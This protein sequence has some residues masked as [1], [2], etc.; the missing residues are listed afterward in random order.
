MYTNVTRVTKKTGVDFGLKIQ[1]NAA[2]MCFYINVKHSFV[3][4][5]V[6]HD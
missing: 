2:S 1:F 3:P 6:P 4:M 5:L